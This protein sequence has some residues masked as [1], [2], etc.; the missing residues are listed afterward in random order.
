MSRSRPPHL[1]GPGPKR[2]QLHGFFRGLRIASAVLVPVCAQACLVPQSV[3]PIG[4]S[5]HP[6]PHFVEQSIPT[7]LIAPVLQ[8]VRQGSL[9]PSNCHCVIEIPPLTVEE[10][11]PTV[12]LEARWF[13]DYAAAG[14]HAIAR[15]DNGGT[16]QGTFND[17]TLT[18]RTLDT[19]R[20]DADSFVSNGVHVLSVVV[21]ETTGFDDSS[22]AALPNRTMKSGYTLAQYEFPINVDVALDR[23][24]CPQQLPSIQVCQ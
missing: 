8:L 3:D 7:Y 19:F 2:S 15:R 20:F 23:T 16:L 21:G 17:P 22:T 12:N 10:D 11:D 14:S 24:H 1:P 6:A 5:A 13:V 9:D 4:A 18:L